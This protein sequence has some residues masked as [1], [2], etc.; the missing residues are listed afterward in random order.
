M[1]PEAVP[2]V[3]F[4]TALTPQEVIARSPPKA[5]DMAISYRQNSPVAEIATSAKGGLAMT[6][7]LCHSLGTSAVQG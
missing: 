2:K 5:D 6:M 7:D 3:L 1:R 4:L